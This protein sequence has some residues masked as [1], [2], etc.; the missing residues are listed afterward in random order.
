M[1]NFQNQSIFTLI[2]K[3]IY[4]TNDLNI[5]HSE[6]IRNAIQLYNLNKIKFESIIFSFENAI[7]SGFS[8]F[9]KIMTNLINNDIMSYLYNIK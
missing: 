4:R 8:I 2:D 1:F 7:T 9:L 3:T 6:Q 5:F